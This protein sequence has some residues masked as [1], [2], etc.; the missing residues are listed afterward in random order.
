MKRKG[1]PEIEPL[2]SKGEANGT[3]LDSLK[4]GDVSRGSK[5]EGKWAVGEKRENEGFVE[6]KFCFLAA[7]AKSLQIAQ[8]VSSYGYFLFYMIVKSKVF[9]NV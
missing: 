4:F 2:R 7:V 9:V 8:G 6:V 5:G 3:I 1:G